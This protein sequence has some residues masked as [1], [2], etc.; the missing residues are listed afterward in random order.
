M[1]NIQDK[2]RN[3][4]KTQINCTA[5]ILVTWC[6]FNTWRDYWRFFNSAIFQFI[7]FWIPS[8]KFYQGKASLNIIFLLFLCKSKL[9]E[10]YFFESWDW[11][12]TCRTNLLKDHACSNISDQFG[13]D[14]WLN[15]TISLHFLVCFCQAVK[16]TFCVIECTL[17]ADGLGEGLMIKTFIGG[18]ASKFLCIH[19]I[20]EAIYSY[21][22]IWVDICNF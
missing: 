18:R 15:M 7:G 21:I 16:M 1:K 19:F 20:F 11:I 13:G 10:K 2:L 14:T 8:L 3:N 22:S 4:T 9:L 6:C 17:L 12:S 5:S